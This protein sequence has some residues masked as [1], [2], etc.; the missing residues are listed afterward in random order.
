MSNSNNIHEL[1]GYKL[2]HLDGSAGKASK[3]PAYDKAKCDADRKS[4]TVGYNDGYFQGHEAFKRKNSKK[5]DNSVSYASHQH[6]SPVMS[7]QQQT[8]L[9]KALAEEAKRLVATNSQR[10]F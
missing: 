6:Q 4:F 3:L 2:G 5:N 7:T 1:R 10:A 9:Q 8:A